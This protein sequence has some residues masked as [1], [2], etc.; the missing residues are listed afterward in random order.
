[1]SKWLDVGV[2]LAAYHYQ[3]RQYAKVRPPA[4]GKNTTI[5][6]LTRERERMQRM[7]EEQLKEELLKKEEELR[8]QNPPYRYNLIELWRE[9]RRKKKKRRSALMYPTSTPAPVP[10]KYS[11][12]NS[13]N[14]VTLC[15]HR[16]NLANTMEKDAI[17]VVRLVPVSNLTTTFLFQ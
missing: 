8:Q 12:Q 1:M 2:N 5:R 13:A 10:E 17:V 11:F 6:N 4:F 15:L 3:C 14:N 7:T 16:V 9:R